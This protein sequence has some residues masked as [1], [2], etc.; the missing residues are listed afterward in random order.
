MAYSYPFKRAPE[1]LIKMVW[2]KG[3]ID[4]SVKS[5]DPATWR[6][7]K[8]GSLMKFSEHGNRTSL[9][10]WEIDHIKPVSKGGSDDL[11]NLQ[12]LNWRNNHKKGDTYPWSCS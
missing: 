11:S 6:W 7:D 1:N 10:G 4:D 2:D 9:D 3:K 5:W 8:C 12:P